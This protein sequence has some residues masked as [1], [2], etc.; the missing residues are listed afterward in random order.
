MEDFFLT[1][2]D[3]EILEFY[4]DLVDETDKEAALFTGSVVLEKDRPLSIQ[5]ELNPYLLGFKSY[6]IFEGSYTHR[7]TPKITLPTVSQGIL[8]DSIFA[9][10][11]EHNPQ[12]IDLDALQAS[13]SDSGELAQQVFL[14]ITQS[15]E[16]LRCAIREMNTFKKKFSRTELSKVRKLL[17]EFYKKEISVPLFSRLPG[18]K[19]P[20]A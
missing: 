18:K 11:K 7:R 6:I 14:S 10:Q 9:P 16:E 4:A 12:I 20:A 2:S 8:Q 5:F 1:A 19:N 3:E 13:M 17:N 15:C